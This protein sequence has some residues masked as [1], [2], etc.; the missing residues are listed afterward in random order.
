MDE[1]RPKLIIV[2]GA[3]S[4]EPYGF[5]L[6]KKLKGEIIKL[7]EKANY[8]DGLPSC[9]EN[10]INLPFCKE[11]RELKEFAKKLSKCRHD[12][13]DACC[14]E[15]KDANFSETAKVL[16][17]YVLLNYTKKFI[18]THQ[19]ERDWLRKFFSLITEFGKEGELK[20]GSLLFLTF[21]YDCVIEYEIEKEVKYFIQAGRND[22]V[23]FFKSIK[24][25]HVYGKLEDDI[26]SDGGLTKLKNYSKGLKLMK[27]GTAKSISQETLEAYFEEA[28]V[29]YFLGFAFHE[30]NLE[31]I[32]LKNILKKCTNWKIMSRTSLGMDAT[33]I[34]IYK[35]GKILKGNWQ[36][37]PDEDCLSLIGNE[38]R[39]NEIK[40]PV[41]G[42]DPFS[43][44]PP[45]DTSIS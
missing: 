38:I 4:S 37:F 39:K 33:T 44:F 13:I 32:D 16:I 45:L 2:T 9:D 28:I 18:N 17:G 11:P 24:V 19:H 7:C 5:P 1:L 15:I 26:P 30:L 42:R 34:D 35:S 6:G 8:N 25:E 41:S 31:F 20:Q 29:I 10:H 23:D 3:G 22:L 36:I 43:I 21:N 27:D 40:N 12:S 14:F